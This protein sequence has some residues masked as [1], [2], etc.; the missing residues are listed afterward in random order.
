MVFYW[1][2]CITPG[3]SRAA[4]SRQRGCQAATFQEACELM[5]GHLERSACHF[6]GDGTQDWTDVQHKINKLILTNPPEYE[7]DEPTAAS[8]ASAPTAEASMDMA[9][10]VD[11]AFVKEILATATQAQHACRHAGQIC[12]AAEAAFKSASARL[13]DAIAALR[14]RTD[15]GRSRSRS[16]HGQGH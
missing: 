5:R 1:S 13:E 6:G 7:P 10:A 16:R 4:W 9:A 11:D 8:A 14:A 3:C 2:A 15:R 12:V